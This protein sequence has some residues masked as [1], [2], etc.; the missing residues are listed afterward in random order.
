MMESSTTIQN[1][2]LEIFDLICNFL[3]IFDIAKLEQTSKTVKDRIE[4]SL[5]WKK[6]ADRFQRRFKFKLTEKMILEL[7]KK[8][9]CNIT[10][11]KFYKIIIGISGH[12]RKAMKLLET[13]ETK[14]SEDVNQEVDTY[15][16][17]FDESAQ[18]LPVHQWIRKVLKLFL[19]IELVKK[20]KIQILTFQDTFQ[21]QKEDE[22]PV[23]ESNDME[24][25]ETSKIN[26]LLEQPDPN[27]DEEI[28]K[29]GSWTESKIQPTENEIMLIAKSKAS[30]IM[31]KLQ[32]RFI[33]AGGGDEDA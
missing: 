13:K 20:K 11:N 2:P 16:S 7:K 3:S 32:Q 24:M 17:N 14:L 23:N 9:L 31:N 19:E 30:S 22:V 4:Q 18:L 27:I 26:D 21:V 6:E 5:I 8:N 25:V 28:V 33:E 29:F 10:N 15:V 12:L 1:V